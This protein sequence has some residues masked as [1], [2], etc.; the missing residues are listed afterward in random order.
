MIASRQESNNKPRQCVKKQRHHFANKSPHSQGFAL[1][2]S[3]VQL[4]EL[5]HKEGRVPKNWHFRTVVLEKT[6]ESL[7]DSKEIKPVNLKGNQAWIL[8]GRADA[9]ADAPILWS[10]DAKS[11]FT[12]KDPDAGE[13]WRQKEKRVTGDE[14]AGWHHQC[15]GH[16]LGQTLGDGKGRGGL[17]CC[18]P[19]RCWVRHDWATEQQKPEPL[20]GNATV[21]SSFFF[22]LLINCFWLLWVFD[23]VRGLSL[24]CW[25]GATL[26]VVHGL[27]CQSTDCRRSGF[28]SCSTRVLE[29][30]VFSGCDTWA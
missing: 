9:E 2:G 10:P 24:L 13:D 23:V 21:P 25:A 17:A 18:S 8:I 12:G 11:F 15:S 26:A 6:L 16:K 28:S 4:W 29:Q 30:A 19:W 7:L 22:F 1:S 14:M 20:E 27:L 5:D 3:H